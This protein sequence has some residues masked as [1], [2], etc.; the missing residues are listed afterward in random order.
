MPCIKYSYFKYLLRNH[1]PKAAT[2]IT[3]SHSKLTMAELKT[4]KNKASVTAF[5]NAVE[6]EQRRKD[7]KELLKIFKE[8]TGMKPIMWGT[9]IIG[10]GQYHY[11]SD[12]STQEGDWPLTGF[13]PRKA[14]MTVYIMPG[15]KDYKKQLEK[16]GKHKTSVSCLYFTKL[17]NIDTTILKQIIKDSVA[18]MKKMYPSK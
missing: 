11:K 17:D 10:F 12:R 8:A 2:F 14:N 13:S 5:I 18:K 1:Y 3:P 15:F 16:I 9:S 7:A 6:N 4:Q